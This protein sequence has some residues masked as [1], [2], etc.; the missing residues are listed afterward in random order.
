[1]VEPDCVGSYHQR[2]RQRQQKTTEAWPWGPS[3]RRYVH[4]QTRMEIKPVVWHFDD[5]SKRQTLLRSM[6]CAVV[7]GHKVIYHTLRCHLG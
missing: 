3:N 1:M 2:D 4:I 7:L 5:L 6:R